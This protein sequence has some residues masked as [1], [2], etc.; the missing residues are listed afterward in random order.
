[1]LKGH[2]D[3]VTAVSITEAADD[4]WVAT[5]GEDGTVRVWRLSSGDCYLTTPPAEARIRSVQW[6]PDGRSLFSIDHIGNVRFL[7]SLPRRERLLQAANAE[8]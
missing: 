7:D 5:G 1:M 3:V 4:E 6:A 2:T 8:Q